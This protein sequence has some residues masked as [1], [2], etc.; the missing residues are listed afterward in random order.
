MRADNTCVDNRDRAKYRFHEM[1]LTSREPE[2]WR[3][4]VEPGAHEPSETSE[5]VATRDYSAER[6]DRPLFA[7]T[8]EHLGWALVAALALVTRLAMLGARPL[9]AAE[10]GRALRQLA[11]LRSGPVAGIHFYWTDLVQAAFFAALGAG[12]FRSRLIF[13]LAGLLLIAGAFAMRRRL[14]RAGAIAFAALLVFSPTVAYYSRAAD[15]LL[16]AMAFAVLALAL[17][18][19]LADEPGKPLAA[20]LGAAIGLMLASDG[21]FGG[22]ADGTAA[23]TALLMLAALAVV[24]L[25]AAIAT[26]Q[27]GLQIRVWWARRRDLFAVT[28]ITAAVVWLALES[29]LFTRSPLG[30]IAS[31]LR[32]NL[33]AIG[34]GDFAAGLDFYLPILALHEFFIVLLGS[35]GALCVLTLRIRAR[36]ATGA[37]MWTGFATAFYLAAPVRSPI[38]VLQIVVPMALLGALA[39]DAVYRT[40]AWNVL[41]YPL[42]LL[43]ILTLYVQTA[44]DF[45]RYAP[46]ASE[47]PWARSA[48][49]YW[50]A[51]ATTLQAKA[52]CARVADLIPARGA[53]GD[54]ADSSPVLRWYLRAL[55]PVS[56]AEGALAI[57][58]SPQPVSVF[59]AQGFNAYEFELSAEWHPTWRSL[60]L[61]KAL[62]YIVRARAWTPLDSNRVTIAV[63]PIVN[64]APTVI[65]APPAPATAPGAAT[66]G[67]AETGAAASPVASPAATAASSPAA[68]V[69]SPATPSASGTSAPGAAASTGPPGPAHGV[70]SGLA[71][72]AASPSAATAETPAAT[73]APS[74]AGT[75]AGDSEPSPDATPSAAPTPAP[76]PAASV[77]HGARTS[78]AHRRERTPPTAPADSD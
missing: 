34:H 64:Q 44:N 19:K 18:L 52:E 54:F 9:D 48:L 2:E 26:R 45:L 76:T 66:P 28:L 12:D 16:P 11:L 74:A 70:A 6:L 67:G 78:G 47:A 41:R 40:A 5:E 24:G 49:L 22:A 46:D 3:L 75:P 61:R 77:E 33:G 20:G 63:R 38:L 57:I 43:A 1:S 51:P 68:G 71:A 25:T 42:L 15:N 23:M 21:A 31:A 32:P 60:T 29:D 39:I 69:E 59:E 53:T 17:F 4:G 62:D 36:L 14:G 30:P 10:A 65:L 37:L 55:A 8:A 72:A 56:T 7:V 27:V 35:I 58:G 73:G 13:A 50:T